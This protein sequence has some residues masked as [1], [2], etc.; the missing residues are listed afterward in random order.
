M[1][2]RILK[3]LSLISN[4]NVL[5]TYR[6]TVLLGVGLCHK[7]RT[8]RRWTS[9]P[10]R[11]Y[12]PATHRTSRLHWMPPTLVSSDLCREVLA[13]YQPLGKKAPALFV[14]T[15]SSD[16]YSV[17]VQQLTLLHSFV[18]QRF[19]TSE[20]QILSHSSTVCILTTRT[21]VNCMLL[22]NFKFSKY[23]YIEYV[24]FLCKIYYF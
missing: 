21:N 3:V 23:L 24:I 12:L 5:L 8:K 14:P 17:A 6:S 20:L 18:L 22:L 9:Q 13:V 4:K 2:S 11:K 7:R 15:R 10:C 1:N 16:H 19:R